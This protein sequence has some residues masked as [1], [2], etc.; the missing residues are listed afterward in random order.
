MKKFLAVL[1]A[2][3]FA[4]SATTVAFAS[5]EDL[6][7]DT[8]FEVL[9]SLT[10]YN[11]HVSGGCLVDFEPCQYCKG[12]IKNENLAAHEA[13]CPKGAGTCE[14]C[15]ADY[16]TQA[17]YAAHKESD[18]KVT[19]SIGDKVPVA[20]LVDKVV[21][22]VKGI[23]WADLGDKVVGAVKGIDFNGLIEKI[24]PVFEKI[25]AFVTEALGEAEV[26]A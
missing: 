11:K 23:D 21:E 19:T 24:K 22:L 4:L 18:C 10:E 25:V 16:G 7:C 13:N 20:T 14:F 9:P 15:G 12:N 5:V 3:M 6:T 8:C 17:E 2:L 26:A 1:F